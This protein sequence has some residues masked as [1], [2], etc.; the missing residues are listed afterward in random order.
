MWNQNLSQINILVPTHGASAS[1]VQPLIRQRNCLSGLSKLLSCTWTAR[2]RYSNR[3]LPLK[4]RKVGYSN[5]V[6]SKLCCQKKQTWQQQYICNLLR[7][8]GKQEMYEHVGNWWKL[9][10]P[11]LGRF[12]FP[13]SL[14]QLTAI[15]VSMSSWPQ[16]TFHSPELTFWLSILLMVQKSGVHQLIIR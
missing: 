13:M 7:P 4:S 5:L 6:A 3:L 14:D 10:H 1:N 12:P 11:K 16:I 2:N 8:S 15:P 9:V